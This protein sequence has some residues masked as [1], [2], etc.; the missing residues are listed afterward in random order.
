M[1]LAESRTLGLMKLAVQEA[2]PGW[3]Q[4]WSARTTSPS[5]RY[6]PP[7]GTCAARPKSARTRSAHRWLQFALRSGAALILAGLEPR[8]Y[9]PRIRVANALAAKLDAMPN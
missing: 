1:V 4:R 2:G 9:A 5:I 6:L 7:P 3:P 8:I